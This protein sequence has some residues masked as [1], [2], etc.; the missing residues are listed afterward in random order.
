MDDTPMDEGQTVPLRFL[1]VLVT[2][3]TTTM[4]VGL[5]VII[6]LLVMRFSAETRVPLPDQIVLPAGTHALAVTRAP[7]WLGVVTDDDRFLIYDL[8]GQKLLQEIPITA[9]QQH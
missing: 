4:I 2:I 9:G 3:L 1:K 6:G 8:S 7:T 5:I